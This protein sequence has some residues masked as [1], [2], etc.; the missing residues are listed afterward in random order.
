HRLIE[1]VASVFSR[2]G[3]QA[4]LGGIHA[5]KPHLEP[6]YEA[7]GFSVLP[8]GTPLDLRLPVGTLRYPAEPSMR[9]LVRPLT[10]T[11]TY[12]AGVLHGVLAEVS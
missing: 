2:Q 1:E 5:H 4:M 8:A 3:A 12:D 9:H 10:D 7:A 6:Y 11:V